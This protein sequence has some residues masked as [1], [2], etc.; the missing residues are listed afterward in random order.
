MTKLKFLSS[1]QGLK[2]MLDLAPRKGLI[3]QCLLPEAE[4][5]LGCSMNSDFKTAYFSPFYDWV[6]G[7]TYL[8]ER[9]RT[10]ESKI[11]ED[12]DLRRTGKLA[13]MLYMLSISFCFHCPSN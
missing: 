6:R 4:V 11:R 2:Y 12:S 7:D 9:R 8:H 1:G 10:S 13:D 5:E 3:R